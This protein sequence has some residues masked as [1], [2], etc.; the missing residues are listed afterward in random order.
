MLF[1]TCPCCSNTLLRHIRAREIHWFCRHC[2]LEMP[3]YDS[4]LADLETTPN[5]RKSRGLTP[6]SSLS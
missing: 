2:Y 3:Y 6:M 4:I 5:V 1:S